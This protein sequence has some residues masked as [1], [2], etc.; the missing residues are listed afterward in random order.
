M[1]NF[2]LIIVALALMLTT[3]LCSAE[4]YAHE[5]ERDKQLRYLTATVYSVDPHLVKITSV[6]QKYQLIEYSAIVTGHQ[7]SYGADVHCQIL[8]DGQ[9]PQCADR[10]MPIYADQQ[11]PVY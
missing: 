10:N 3:G 9:M 6:K 7:G 2:K 11:P 8:S 1:T 5:S 4:E